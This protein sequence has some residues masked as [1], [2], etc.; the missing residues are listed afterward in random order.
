MRTVG[1]SVWAGTTPKTFLGAQA[2]KKG[3]R[4]SPSRAHAAPK[5]ESA[6]HRV[7]SFLS[8]LQNRLGERDGD[9]EGE[10]VVWHGVHRFYRRRTLEIL[11]WCVLFSSR[12]SVKS[13]QN[14]K[15]IPCCGYSNE[16]TPLLLATG[17]QGRSIS[18]IPVHISNGLP[19]KKRFQSLAFMHAEKVRGGQ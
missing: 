3:G 17:S 15:I 11:S 10:P 2:E 18:E 4:S 8:D 19:G 12:R 5:T 16:T 14:G 13:G 1:D 9:G 6:L 7:F